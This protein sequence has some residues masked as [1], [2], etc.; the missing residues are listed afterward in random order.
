ML[1]LCKSVLAPGGLLYLNYNTHPGWT[2][3]GMVR[4]FLMKQTTGI[5]SLEERAEQC[6][7]IAA[8]VIA[9]LKNGEHAYTELMAKQ[10]QMVVDNYPA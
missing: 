5:D 7:E 4:D 6:R 10:F 2:V 9:P 8:R 3:R 1:E